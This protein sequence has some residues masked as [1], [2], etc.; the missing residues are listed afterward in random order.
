MVGSAPSLEG[1]CQQPPSPRF[2]RDLV[3]PL[4]ASLSLTQ[5]IQGSVRYAASQLTD[6][7]AV[8]KEAAAS[9]K[10]TLL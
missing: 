2:W 4:R 1:G 9:G 10:V 7:S 6:K 3:K 8:L 5:A